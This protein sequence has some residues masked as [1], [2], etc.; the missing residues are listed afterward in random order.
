MAQT[1]LFNEHL[2]NVTAAATDTTKQVIVQFSGG[3]FGD[4]D[5]SFTAAAGQNSIS[6]AESESRF[7]RNVSSEIKTGLAG[8]FITCHTGHDICEVYVYCKIKLFREL[9]IQ[10]RR[11][12]T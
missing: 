9:S 5:H 4:W 2:P 6:T 12:V 11:F 7:T 3:F 1:A 10:P 8:R